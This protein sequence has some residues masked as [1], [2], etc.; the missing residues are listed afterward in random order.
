MKELK[1]RLYKKF[2]LGFNHYS[3]FMFTKIPNA[4]IESKNFN[5]MEK[6]VLLVLAR[7]NPCF[8]SFTKISEM[9]GLSRSSVSRAIKS[10]KRRDAITQYKRK[11]RERV[12][13]QIHIGEMKKEIPDDYIDFG[14]IGDLWA[15]SVRTQIGVCVHTSGVCVTLRAVS[16]RT[17]NKTK[18]IRIKNKGIF[19]SFFLK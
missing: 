10:L 12:Y 4:F 18:R 9:T 19:F 13:Y 1:P 6:L 15:V 11:N 2:H 5:P 17:S 8:P 3:S 16:V 14:S 7:Y